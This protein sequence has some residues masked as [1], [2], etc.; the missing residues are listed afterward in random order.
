VLYAIL[1]S[2]GIWLAA[3]TFLVGIPVGL[4]VAGDYRRAKASGI[5]NPGAVIRNRF[6]IPRRAR[7]GVARV[8]GREEVWVDCW[9]LGCVMRTA[10]SVVDSS[11]GTIV[12]DAGGK[13]ITFRPVRES[14]SFPGGRGAASGVISHDDAAG[15]GL[16][17]FT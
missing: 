6:F 1:Y 12:I 8:T 2:A 5:S 16:V 13:R 3:V 14:K 7:G 11:E 17:M 10:G 9:R 4:A 15:Y